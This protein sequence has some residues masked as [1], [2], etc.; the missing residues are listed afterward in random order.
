MSR[1]GI[2]P[3]STRE[4]RFTGEMMDKVKMGAAPLHFLESV[5]STNEEL[6]RLAAHGAVPG[7]AVT[8]R[9]QTAGRGRLGRSWHSAEGR[10]IYISFL[11]PGGFREAARSS[12]VT[13][14]AVCDLLE[15]RFN[16][17]PQ[18]KWPNDVVVNGCKICGVLLE[19]REVNGR[20]VAVAGLGLNTNWTPE[21]YRGD[22]RRTPVSLNFFTREPVDHE[23]VVADLVQ[24]CRC[25]FQQAAGERGWRKILHR[26]ERRLYG[27]GKQVIINGVA[28]TVAGLGPEGELLLAQENGRQLINSGELEFVNWH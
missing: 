19:S 10:G 2:Q 8:A 23:R 27:A 21:D 17:Q 26:V 16:L 13:A 24:R 3:V 22:Y 5:D 25:L 4:Y 7:T 28:G 14:A 11:L 18:I 1:A 12:I 6:F 20:R 15:K 9:V